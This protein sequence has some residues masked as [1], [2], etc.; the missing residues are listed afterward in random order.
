LI[1]DESEVLCVVV[2][3]GSL[4]KLVVMNESG[5]MVLVIAATGCDDRRHIVLFHESTEE[6]EL[7][8]TWPIVLVP[9]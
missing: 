6:T 8:L 3:V 2:L 1:D 7:M 4:F 9:S 5:L